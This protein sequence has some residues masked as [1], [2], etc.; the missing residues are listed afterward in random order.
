MMIKVF[1]FLISLRSKKY[2]SKKTNSWEIIVWWLKFLHFL[3]SLH[4]KKY[5]SKKTHSWEIVVF[6]FSIDLFRFNINYVSYTKKYRTLYNCD[7][8]SDH[9]NVIMPLYHT[10]INSRFYCNFRSGVHWSY[11]KWQNI[12]RKSESYTSQHTR[13]YFTWIGFRCISWYYPVDCINTHNIVYILEKKISC[14][15]PNWTKWGWNW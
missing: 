7:Q 12:Q 4:S 10:V 3:I 9:N 6:F 13:W 2:V 5:V 11:W 14:L 1:H 8:K 15:Y